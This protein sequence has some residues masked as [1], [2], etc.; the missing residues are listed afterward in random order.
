[1]I[2]PIVIDTSSIVDQYASI[3]RTDI[4]Q[5]LDNIA[6]GLA[7]RFASKLE[8]EA[9]ETLKSS[10]NR[11]INN[12]KV[13]DNGPLT[14]TVLLD[15]SKDKLIKMLEEGASAF[16]MKEGFLA[17]PKVKIGKNG[18]KFL[19]IPFRMATPNA[20]GESGVFAKVMPK[21]IYKEVKKK[22]P[23]IPVAGGGKRSEGLSLA[24]IPEAFQ[25]KSTRP[26][27]TDN[28]GNELFK[29]YEHKSSIYQGLAKYQDAATGQSTYRSFRRVS[30][31]SADEAWI[32]PGIERHNLIQ[33][34]LGNFN[35]AQEMTTLMDQELNKLGLL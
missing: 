6:K 8:Q 26:S 10:R 13:V 31:A 5:M 1:M 19:T 33:K 9:Q 3:K 35:V 11:Y 27:I 30:E 32:H 24:Q 34:A 15:Y 29:S 21:E 22:V 16:D 28:K 23:T 17:S 4:D 25:V 14:G 12:I 20:V 2:M 7:S 18:K